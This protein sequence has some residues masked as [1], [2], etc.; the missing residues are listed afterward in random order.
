[1]WLRPY[2]SLPST[3]VSLLWENPVEFCLKVQQR[4]GIRLWETS[5][6]ETSVPSWSTK[7]PRNY[8]LPGQIHRSMRSSE[9]ERKAVLYFA[10]NSMPYTQS[11]Y[12]VR[13]HGMLRAYNKTNSRK[14]ICVT[15]L[16]YPVV[17]GRIPRSQEDV[18][19]GV[20]YRRIIP[21]FFFPSSRLRAREEIRELTKIAESEQVGVIHTT[22]DFRNAYVASQVAK[23]LS[24]PWVYEVRGERENT[25]LSQFEAAERKAAAA[26]GY[27]NYAHEKEMEAVG[28]AGSAIFLS[29]VAKEYAVSNGIDPRLAW[30]IPNSLPEGGK[31]TEGHDSAQKLVSSLLD[32]NK[33][34]I[35]TVSSLVHYEG[36]SIVIRALPYLPVEVN[37]L[38]V[39]DG[40][41][42][43]R[44]EALARSLGVHDRVVFAGKQPT[45]SIGEWYRAL[46]VF[47]VPRISSLVTARVTP[48]KPLEAMRVGI[49][50]LASDLPALHEVTGEFAVY[51]A[52]EQ[53]ED[54]VRKIK[55]ILD[56]NVEIDQERVDQ[57]LR[58]RTWEYNVKK[59]EALYSELTGG[60]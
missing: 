33:I 20:T 15:R 8:E 10:N 38:F 39:G 58:T 25:W 27:Y 19:S 45:E 9:D 49:P 59:L 16:G 40:T 30:V 23:R 54:F 5:R 21:R 29:E 6:K 28:K 52:P 7:E 3:I 32:N 47:V 37:A 35:G 11:G 57:W 48:I 26:S 36:L 17:V 53:L 44:L 1:M 24:I 43:R 2:F 50:V 31:A 42:R 41:E 4:F 18:L 60:K 14:I 34:Y 46:D 55:M 56:G 22:T 13:T 51:F 12:T